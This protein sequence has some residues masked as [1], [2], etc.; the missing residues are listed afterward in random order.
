MQLLSRTHWLLDYAFQ[1]GLRRS[2]SYK[3]KKYLNHSRLNFNPLTSLTKTIVARST[4]IE[5]IT[6]IG[7]ESHTCLPAIGWHTTSLQLRS[8]IAGQ[9]QSLALSCKT[10]YAEGK[11]IWAKARQVRNVHNKKFITFW[12]IQRLPF[13]RMFAISYLIALVSY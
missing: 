9:V 2:L 11:Y 3:F 8:E 6:V 13:I 5:E 4:M 1:R 7:V 10:N 12:K